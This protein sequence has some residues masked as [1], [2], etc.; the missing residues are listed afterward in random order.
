MAEEKHSIR[1]GI[2][3]AVGA[4]FLIWLGARFL[5]VLPSVWE[6][7]KWAVTG[8]WKGL[9]YSA[10]LPVWLILLLSLG[11]LVTIFRI[12][13]SFRPAESEQYVED[14]FFDV[15]WRWSLISGRPGFSTVRGYCPDDD[16]ALVHS[17]WELQT[18]FHCETCGRKFGPLK[19]D[20]AFVIGSVTRQIDRKLRIGG[21]KKSD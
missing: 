16:T 11:A 14:V 18:T 20:Y 13:A 17:G 3:I 7:V 6:W 5:G 15:R 9:T 12:L 21:W 8:A 2:V 1:N 19:G 4:A 10:S